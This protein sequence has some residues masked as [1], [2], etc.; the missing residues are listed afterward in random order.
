M[1]LVVPFI[2]MLLSVQV[3][4]ACNQKKE[5]EQDTLVTE[6]VT[7]SSEEEIEEPPPPGFVSKYKTLQEW[8]F[9]LCYSEEPKNADLDYHFGL[10]ES[11]DEKTMVLTGVYTYNKDKNHSVSKIEFEPADMYYNLP[12]A[13][14]EGIT[15]A[16]LQDRLARQLE[17]FTKS[18]K[19]RQSFFHKAKSVIVDWKGEIWR[20]K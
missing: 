4:V 7:V 8:L 2:S 13:E 6:T 15:S 9:A 10:F 3:L 19:F 16:Q 14:F 20:R 5:A 11:P 1:K 12:K 17:A 18:E